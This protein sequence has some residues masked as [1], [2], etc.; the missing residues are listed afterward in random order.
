VTAIVNRREFGRKTGRKTEIITLTSEVNE[1]G[2]YHAGS[3]VLGK[4]VRTVLRRGK[5]VRVYLFHFHSHS[6]IWSTLGY[7]AIA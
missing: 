1:S 6:G 2:H 5:P 7:L 4:L 3:R